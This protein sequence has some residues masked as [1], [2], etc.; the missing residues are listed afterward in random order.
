MHILREAHG[1]EHLRAEHAAVPHLNPLVQH[2]M[3]RENLKGRLD[4]STAVR[5]SARS[6]Q[7]TTRLGVWIV[8]GLK[9]DVFDSHLAEEHPHES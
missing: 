3:E 7:N 4:Q 8:C 6:P 5:I 2:W 9:A 1:L